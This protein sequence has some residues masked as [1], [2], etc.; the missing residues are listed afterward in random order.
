MERAG[1]T[2]GKRGVCS[3]TSPFWTF[4]LTSLSFQNRAERKRL[5]IIIVAEGAIDCHNKAITPDYIK[6]VSRRMRPPLLPKPGL[7]SQRLVFWFFKLEFPFLF[8]I[9][10]KIK[11]PFS[12]LRRRK[13]LAVFIPPGACL[14]PKILKSPLFLSR[15]NALSLTFRSNVCVTK[16]VK[17]PS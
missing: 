13:R 11:H 12:L 2:K 5:N 10:H 14:S 16:R 6:D 15:L 7:V 4:L 8:V 1:F 3:T 9:G 17:T